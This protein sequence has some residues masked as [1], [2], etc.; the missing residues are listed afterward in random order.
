MAADR[1]GF[2]PAS[3]SGGGGDHNP[4]TQPIATQS[5]L[6]SPHDLTRDTKRILDLTTTDLYGST[7]HGTTGVKVQ[8][9]QAGAAC[10]LG[11]QEGS[12]TAEGVKQQLHSVHLG[13]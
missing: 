7:H 11:V 4:I 10:S 1:Y 13:I 12:S 2:S 6:I 5:M 8:G 9:V 3:M